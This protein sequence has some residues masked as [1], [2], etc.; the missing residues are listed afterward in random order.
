MGLSRGTSR[1]PAIDRRFR[2]TLAAG[3]CGAVLPPVPLQA[4][5]SPTLRSWLLARPEPQS[6]VL[7][8]GPATPGIPP[9]SVVGEVRVAAKDLFDTS[10][11]G[12]D[13]RLLPPP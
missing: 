7:A 4:Q 8:A 3:F 12:E 2:L 11:P 1:P 9:G 5:P 13:R 10:N 6:P